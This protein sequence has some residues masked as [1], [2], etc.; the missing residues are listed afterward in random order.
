MTD[1]L[2]AA[3][4]RLEVEGQGGLPSI[5][6]IRNQRVFNL[7]RLEEKCH[8]CVLCIGKERVGSCLLYIDV[9]EEKVGWRQEG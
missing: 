3:G 4:W 9:V 1:L 5:S 8:F 2:E 6:L 7:I